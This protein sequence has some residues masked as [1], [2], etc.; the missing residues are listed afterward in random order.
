MRRAIPH[1]PPTALSP[2]AGCRCRRSPGALD[3]FQW[4]V[5]VEAVEKSEGDVL[6]SKLE[7]LVALGMARPDV[8]PDEEPAPVDR[9]RATVEVKPEPTPVPAKEAAQ[10]VEP[11]MPEV[12]ARNEATAKQGSVPNT[13]KPT[14][15]RASPGRRAAATQRGPPTRRHD[16]PEPRQ[17]AGAGRSAHLH[18]AARAGRP[19]PRSGRG[20]RRH[21]PAASA[22]GLMAR[23]KWP[24]RL[25]HL[26]S[27]SA[28]S[29][30]IALPR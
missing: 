28:L 22:A 26:Q 27:P 1:G 9:P 18:A 13:A 21:H 10:R 8:E 23:W 12:E 20:R 16:K 3:A 15:K 14:A 7:E 6:A 19:G 2:I 5:P 25:L 4:R 11:E 29:T 30:A 17:E 24:A